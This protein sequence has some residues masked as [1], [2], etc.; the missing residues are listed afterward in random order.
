VDFKENHVDFKEGPA[1]SCSANKRA[2][3]PLWVNV[4]K[5]TAGTE[6]AQPNETN[7]AMQSGD[8]LLRDGELSAGTGRGSRRLPSLAG[9]LTVTLRSQ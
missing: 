8:R 2:T 7:F 6:S 9:K 1:W 5:T 4:G 3:N